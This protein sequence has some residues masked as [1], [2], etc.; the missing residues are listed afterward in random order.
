M[1][2]TKA[3]TLAH[4]LGGISSDISTAEINRLDGLT[5]DIQTQITA[6]DNAKAPKASPQFTGNVS[7]TNIKHAS[8]GSNNLVLASDGSATFSGNTIHSSAYGY[9]SLNVSNTVDNFHDEM[10]NTTGSTDPYFVFTGDTTNISGS[11]NHDILLGIKGIYF[12]HGFFTMYGNTGTYG[13]EYVF[14]VNLRGNGS[15]SESTNVIVRGNSFVPASVDA[16][17]TYNQCSLSTV[18]LFNA[19]D[20]INIEINTGTSGNAELNS[21][22]YL[23]ICLIRQVA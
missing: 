10:I 8:S 3:T 4:T 21:R 22:S 14:Q 1:A 12:I 20:K 2:T 17:A 9:A 18:K 15:T 13:G 5:G 7:A 11:G 6:L 16:T 23:N 19:G